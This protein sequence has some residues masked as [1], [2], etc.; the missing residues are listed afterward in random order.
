LNNLLGQMAYLD[1]KG[2]KRKT[3][4][5]RRR[6]EKQIVRATSVTFHRRASI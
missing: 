2:E 3:S 6:K 4:V 1:K 5:D